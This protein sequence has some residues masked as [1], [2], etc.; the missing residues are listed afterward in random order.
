MYKVG[1]WAALILFAGG[2]AAQARGQAFI[3]QPADVAGSRTVLVLGPEARG[4]V[5]QWQEGAGHLATAMRPD[6]A[7][8]IEQRQSGL[9]NA[10]FALQSD[11]DGSAIIHGQSGS[12]LSASSR[13]VGQVGALQSITQAGQGHVAMQV[14]AQPGL[15]AVQR[16]TQSGNGSTAVQILR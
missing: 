6:G 5:M 9:G 4:I 12:A 13:M 14:M 10:S 7:G 8:R 1:L 3:E 2:V 16:I 11:S 15:G